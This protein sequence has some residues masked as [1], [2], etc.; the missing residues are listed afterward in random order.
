MMEDV[1]DEIAVEYAGRLKVCQIEIEESEVL[2]AEFEVDVVPM[3]VVFKEGKP[4]A[5]ASGVL[6]KEVLMDM[7]EE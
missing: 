1:L 3:F 2:A 6:A 4:T 7:I 5:A